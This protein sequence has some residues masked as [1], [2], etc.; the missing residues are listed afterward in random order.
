M[1]KLIVLALL[2]WGAVTLLRRAREGHEED[3]AAEKEAAHQAAIANN[4]PTQAGTP[5]S[6]PRQIAP[7][8]IPDVPSATDTRQVVP[9][10]IPPAGGD[11][12]NV[13]AADRKAAYEKMQKDRECRSARYNLGVLQSAAK[14]GGEVTSMSLQ[15]GGI[16]VLS[17]E[18]QATKR[19]EYERFIAANCS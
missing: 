16:R 4:F 17:T 1:K 9:V 5:G 7:V 12:V 11:P 14:S 18:Q 8:P 19:A 15:K 10:P 2:G 13:A 6:G 3:M